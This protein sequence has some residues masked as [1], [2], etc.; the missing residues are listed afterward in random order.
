MFANVRLS[1]PSNK[2]ALA[3]YEADVVTNAYEALVDAKAYEADVLLFEYE[4]L[5]LLFEYEALVATKA[6]EALVAFNAY[7]ALVALFAYDADIAEFVDPVMVPKTFRLPVIVEDPEI[8]G[9]FS[10][11]YSIYF[12]IASLTLQTL[13]GY[14]N[15]TSG[16]A[17]SASS[18]VLYS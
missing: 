16:S 17:I 10:I 2:S 9:E 4:A 14:S 1:L 7:E 18:N 15:C 5:V 11:I 8:Y 3:A 12:Y 13:S 6:N